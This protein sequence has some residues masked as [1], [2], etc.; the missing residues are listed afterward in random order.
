MEKQQ[1]LE[2]KQALERMR[3]IETP[4]APPSPTPT[5]KGNK[6]DKRKSNLRW[7][8]CPKVCSHVSLSRSL[9]LTIF[10][11]PHF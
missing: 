5:K 8:R 9:T 4:P 3:V 6:K 7:K 11:C 1:A 10:S 2:K